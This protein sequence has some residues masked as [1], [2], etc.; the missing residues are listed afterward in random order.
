M[1]HARRYAVPLALAGA[2]L[3]L[4]PVPAPAV[5]PKK[6]AAEPPATD[7]LTM[8]VA[9]GFKVELLYSVP[10]EAQ[11]SWVSMCT[12]PKG[13]LIVSDQYGALYRVT[14][15]KV[16]AAGETSVEKLS[17]EIGS[18]QGLLWAFDSL[19]V[20]VNA[21][22]KGKNR[23][24]GLY[25][26][27]SSKKDDTLDTVELLRALEGGGG[28]HGPHAVLLNPDGKRLTVV[29]GNQTKLTKLES[30]DVP[31]VWGE[32]H[33]LP[34]LPDG[35]GFMKG[36]LGPGG[37]IYDVTPDG[38]NWQLQSTGYRNQY[39]AAYHANGDLF[40]YD[41]DMEWDFNTPW[42]RPTRVCYAAPGV[43]FGWRNGAGKYPPHYP[44]TLPGVLDIGPGSPT[45]VTF[46]YGAKF[47]A[48]YQ[49][50]FF[51]CDWSYGKLYAVHLE[52]SGASYKATAE[53]FVTGT[54]LPLT[55]LVV[56]PTDGALYFAIG[57]RRT[58]S[59]LYRVTYTGT[60]STAPAK[61][62]ARQESELEKTR[63]F[64]IREMG[65]VSADINRAALKNLDSGDRTIRALARAALE[66]QGLKACDYNAHPKLD[67]PGKEI[68]RALAVARLSAPCPQ[69]A[70]TAKPDAATR[71]TVLTALNAL[72]WA[73]L[74]P[75]EKLEL[76]RAYQV[77]LNRLGAPTADERAALLSKLKPA[78]PSNNRFLDGML[79]EILVFLQDETVAPKA[80]KLLKDAPTQEEQIEYARS[81]R[82][83]KTGWAPDL[84]KD[85]FAWFV[86]A[87]NYKGGNSF[88][89]FLKLIRDDAVKALE[90]AEAAALGELVKGDP[91]A[92]KL[93]PEP[94]RPFVK[95][96]KMDDLVPK[97]DALKAGRD[98]DRGRKMFAAAKCFA[99]HR[100]DGEGG[101]N[102]PDLTGAAGRF[103]ARDLLESTI[104]P[105]KEI[106]DQYAAVEIRTS[107]ERVVV[108]RIVNLNNDNVMV[109]TDMFNPGAT[110]NVDR[111]LIESMRQSKV[112]MMPTGLLDTLKEDEV[113]D[114]L[115]YMLSR[116]DRTGA[117]FK[118]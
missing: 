29:C 37:A 17:V 87:A 91:A 96:Y 116:G 71:A 49:H 5:Q 79:L 23:G 61:P 34:R 4:K 41:A 102:A 82:M 97:L 60:E 30:S 74:A 62:A 89:K 26:V 78:F 55:D 43:D 51:I 45:G 112:S 8:K 19:Y 109:N 113:L 40:T 94:P 105:S 63:Q 57:G 65:N 66:H 25:R 85:Y 95:A 56:N 75:T 11:G 69:H 72:D 88:A 31:Q 76:A 35:N 108:G 101:S 32:D 44:D 81:L 2:L 7:P 110:V 64:F 107:D 9:K 58:K 16:G 10:K 52:P 70:P 103:S 42:Y 22:G 80:I 46:G 36:V 83:L 111:K 12:D 115:A 13:R 92:V 47:P 59:G 114:L 118:K 1:P 18:A 99:C 117:M 14:P 100:F 50:A 77:A 3:A 73:K 106:S 33:L 27:T 104:E 24:S 48:K 20:V 86:R 21:G 15:P 90:P 54:P 6:A 84:R 39:D 93:P 67:T 68:A 38:K 98:Y 28:E 53:E